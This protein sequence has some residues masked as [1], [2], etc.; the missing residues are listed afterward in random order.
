MTR[1]GGLFTR[2]ATPLLF[3]YLQHF[4]AVIINGP[5]QSGKSTLMSHILPTVGG[6]LRTLDDLGERRSALTDPLAY[7]AQGARPTMIDEVQRGGDDLVLAVKAQTDRDTAPGQ[8]ILA[9]STRFLTAPTLS[10]SL[11]ERAAGSGHRP[12]AVVP[13][14]I[15]SRAPVLHR[16]CV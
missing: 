2:H 15:G 5:Q 8:F 7:V 11:A 1:Q 3:D 4:R 16:S 13:G 12:L 10:E 9:G 14:G 6:T